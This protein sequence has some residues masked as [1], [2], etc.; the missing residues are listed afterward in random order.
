[1]LRVCNY[2]SV[3]APLWLS[4]SDG[5]SDGRSD[6]RLGFSGDIR[7]Y[8]RPRPRPVIVITL[9]PVINDSEDYS[10][11]C[12]VLRLIITRRGESVGWRRNQ[13]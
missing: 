2:R 7:P 8:G 5:R 3:S 1:M 4:R 11:D 12:Y 10:F 13:A 6:I 9:T